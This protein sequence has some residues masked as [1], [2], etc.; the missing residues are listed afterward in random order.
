MN[1][2]SVLVVEDNPADTILIREYLS[3]RN[4]AD[5]DIKEEDTL[6]SAIG[7]ISKHD[8]DVILLDLFL[9]DSAGLD[10]VRRVMSESPDIPVIVLTGLQDEEVAFQAVRYG[11]QDYLEKQTLSP[12]LLYKSI[13]YAIDRK[14]I[15]QEKEDLLHDFTKA[16]QM[17]EKLEKIL[18][19][20]VS[21]RK[22]SDNE[23]TWLRLEDYIR[24]H[25]NAQ[26]GQ[27][28]C[29]SCMSELQETQQD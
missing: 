15:A 26:A 4:D 5:Y 25:A 9:S 23:Q 21:C 19:V 22:I 3:E 12:A 14:R 18:P 24:Q 17:I 11:A 7:L 13:T 16:L 6:E 20:C 29:P 27:I 1:K 8:Y 2:I 28:V 10:T